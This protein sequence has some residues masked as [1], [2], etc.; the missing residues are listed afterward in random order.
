M[1]RHCVCS[2]RNFEGIL[3]GKQ[4]ERGTPEI[5]NPS[6]KI[7]MLGAINLFP[8]EEEQETRRPTFYFQD[9]CT[10]HPMLFY[11]MYACFL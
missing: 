4:M 5:R 7:H 3:I 1:Q 11:Q 6:R 2:Q 8:E 10:V 9:E